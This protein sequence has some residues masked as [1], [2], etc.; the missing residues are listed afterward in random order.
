MDAYDALLVRCAAM[1]AVL[2]ALIETHPNKPALRTA[3]EASGAAIPTRM[4]GLLEQPEMLGAYHA[5][6]VP[7]VRH[8]AGQPPGPSQPQ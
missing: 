6:L 4:P 7:Y 1:S 3:I 8:C 5:A 2:H